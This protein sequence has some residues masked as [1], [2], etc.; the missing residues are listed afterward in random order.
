[1]QG[2]AMT[3]KKRIFGQKIRRRF[4]EDMILMLLRRVVHYAIRPA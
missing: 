2:H 1:M 3:R 4:V